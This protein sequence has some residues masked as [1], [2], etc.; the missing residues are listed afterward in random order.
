[1]TIRIML[2]TLT[3]I[4]LQPS[5]EAVTANPRETQSEPS[6]LAS[7]TS[8]Q[9]VPYSHLDP[10][11]PNILHGRCGFHG[12]RIVYVAA[13]KRIERHSSAPI[14]EPSK[15][16]YWRWTLDIGTYGFTH[17]RL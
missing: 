5:S 14:G 17:P 2:V 15:N 9:V 6:D 7:L 13:T 4:L 1:M 12:E 8:L 11:K 10:T 16:R 3:L